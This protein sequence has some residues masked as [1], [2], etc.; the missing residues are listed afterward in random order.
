[1]RRKKTICL[2]DFIKDL[3]LNTLREK[4]VYSQL[5]MTLNMI[6]V[7]TLDR[8]KDIQKDTEIVR[9]QRAMTLN[10]IY[11]FDLLIYSQISYNKHYT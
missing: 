7:S 3:F 2:L 6:Y 11:G 1:M 10:K 9:I 8:Q 5:V 4:G